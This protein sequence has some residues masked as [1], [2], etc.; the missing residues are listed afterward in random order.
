M[1]VV[2]GEVSR[3][4]I[5]HNLALVNAI[6]STSAGFFAFG[7]VKAYLHQRCNARLVWEML[8]PDE[9]YSG[10]YTFRAFSIPNA[11]EIHI[12]VDCT[13]TPDSVLW[14]IL[15]ELAHVDVDTSIF[16]TAFR[17]TRRARNYATSD[18]VH[19][20][21]NE[22]KLANFVADSI[23]ENVLGIKGGYNRTWWRARVNRRM[24]Q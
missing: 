5:P 2:I 16:A 11:R 7:Y 8:F 24:L 4:Y 22:E 9:L 19:E 18:K 14:I 13:E 12:F 23:M 15:H 3:Y 10:D 20:A 21:N 6:C 17:S 1:E